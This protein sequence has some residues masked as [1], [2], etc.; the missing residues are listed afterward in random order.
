MTSPS[1]VELP[2]ATSRIVV[3]GDADLLDQL[4]LDQPL[5]RLVAE[6]QDRAADNLEDLVAERRGDAADPHGDV[7]IRLSSEE[8]GHVAAQ[9]CTAVIR[10]FDPV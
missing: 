6:V 10:P 1:G 3:Q 5:S 9:Y 4:A 2:G 7:L 8:L